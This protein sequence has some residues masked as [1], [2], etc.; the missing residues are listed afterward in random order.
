MRRS[1]VR[2]AIRPGTANPLRRPSSIAP[3]VSDASRLIARRSRARPVYA[4]IG[5]DG[6]I[7]G[8]GM[9]LPDRHGFEVPD[10]V[11]SRDSARI[12]DG[13]VLRAAGQQDRRRRPRKGHAC[14]GV[15][16]VRGRLLAR[17]RTLRGARPVAVSAEVACGAHSRAWSSCMLCSCA[18]EKMTSHGSQS[19]PS[20]GSQSSPS[21]SLGPASSQP[22]SWYLKRWCLLGVRVG[23]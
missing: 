20:H 6:V 21:P 19:S 12:E 11:M 17:L 1:A 18:S 7:P 16:N 9:V 23:S 8:A 10:A 15:P 5:V 2:Y 4:S 13:T 3:V 14:P 22:L